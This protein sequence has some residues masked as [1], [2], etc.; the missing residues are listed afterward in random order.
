MLVHSLPTG[1]ITGDSV[2]LTPSAD[3]ICQPFHL[4][5]YEAGCF[6]LK[7]RILLQQ[8]QENSSE[9]NW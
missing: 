3:V 5:P 9:T 4:D 8:S 1:K 6:S 2:M 7:G